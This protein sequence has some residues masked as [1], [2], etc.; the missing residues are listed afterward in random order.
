[1]HNLMNTPAY[2][3]LAVFDVNMNV[4]A[5]DLSY[6]LATLVRPQSGGVSG[7]TL[8]VLGIFG[9]FARPATS[10]KALGWASLVL[11]ALITA[12]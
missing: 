4:L 2:A 7:S 9:L 3:T 5:F 8:T 12:R 11:V 1:M 6:A 10:L